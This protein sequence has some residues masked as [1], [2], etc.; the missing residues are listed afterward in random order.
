M[1]K[2]LHDRIGPP[3]PEEIATAEIVKTIRSL[4]VSIL[5]FEEDLESLDDEQKQDLLAKRMP[6]DIQIKDIIVERGRIKA[7][8]TLLDETD[9]DDVILSIEEN[10]DV[11]IRIEGIK[12]FDTDKIKQ[13]TIAQIAENIYKNLV[14]R[15][16]HRGLELPN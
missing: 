7:L 3:S 5:I 1:S 4:M 2:S 10:Y 13:F 11:E 8:D 9:I 12:T 16:L 6:V 15:D 14:D